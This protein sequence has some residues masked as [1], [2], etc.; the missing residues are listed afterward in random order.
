MMYSGVSVSMDLYAVLA[1]VRLIDP[2]F[3]YAE[4][5]DSLNKDTVGEPPAPPPPPAG[6][7]PA[8]PIKGG[9]TSEIT[10][11]PPP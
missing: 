3:R 8:M 10:P 5:P 6:L 9:G 7:A 1:C 11:F 4:I 2:A